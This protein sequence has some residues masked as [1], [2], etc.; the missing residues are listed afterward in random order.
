MAFD[1]LIFLYKSD[2]FKKD[3]IVIFQLLGWWPFFLRF[4]FEKIKENMAEE[5]EKFILFFI[6]HFGRQV[7]IETLKEIK[8]LRFHI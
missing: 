8:N 1:F 2:K 5:K 4:S 3:F 6:L 7:V